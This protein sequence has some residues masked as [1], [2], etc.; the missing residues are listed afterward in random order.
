MV[1]ETR[2]GTI[3][4]WF[5]T[6]VVFISLLFTVT[7]IV[8]VSVGYAVLL[9]ALPFLLYRGYKQ[10]TLTPLHLWLLITYVY[11]AF[12]TL[13]YDAGS[14]LR[15][16]FY[17]H[18]GSFFPLFVPVLLCS[19]M[20][21]KIEPIRMA[22]VFTV[23]GSGINALL[24]AWYLISPDTCINATG[25]RLYFYSLF[26]SHSAAGGFILCLCCCA[27]G[28]LWTA[29]GVKKK[30]L[31]ALPFAVDVACLVAVDSRGSL[32]GAAAIACAALWIYLKDK[33]VFKKSKL[34]AKL[35]VYAFLAVLLVFLLGVGAVR[36]ALAPMDEYEICTLN[37]EAYAEFP[38]RLENSE[39]GQKLGWIR[40]DGVTRGDTII[41]R[42]FYLWPRAMDL[43]LK[44]PVFGMGTGSYD[45]IRIVGRL[46]VSTALGQYAFAGQNLLDKR[47]LNQ[48][49]VYSSAHAHNSYLHVM[50]EN[51]AV[52]LL[53]ILILCF[54]MRKT[55]LAL[56]NQTLRLSLYFCLIG[57]LVAS[58]FENRLFSPAHMLPFVLLLGIAM[59]DKPKNA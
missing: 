18:D 47:I 59:S 12:C 54:L 17:R 26:T 15:Y 32:L 33:G 23:V 10:K 3:W 7:N 49:V 8:P 43:F 37:S 16:A 52:G 41:D 51:G 14:L 19:L 13:R 55:I 42:A 53:L 11:F 38:T 48:D 2:V 9:P 22:R 40:N 21:W 30:L 56:P 45:D 50:A 58:F 28:F 44:S 20:E 39:L 1:V 31:W 34:L 5:G 24:Y 29:E 36:N 4:K 35:D 57:V 25:E 27:L 6:C 46:S